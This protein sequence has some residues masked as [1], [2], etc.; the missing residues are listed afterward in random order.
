MYVKQRKANCHLLVTIAQNM[1]VRTLSFYQAVL[2]DISG[3][4]RKC[5]K[6]PFKLRMSPLQCLGR[7]AMSGFARVLASRVLKPLLVVM[8]SYKLYIKYIMEINAEINLRM[9]IIITFLLFSQSSQSTKQR[10]NRPKHL[11]RNSFVCTYCVSFLT[12]SFASQ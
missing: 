7:S 3:S 12:A 9:K 10:R 1:Q 8:V 4:Q 11:K 6:H 2:E 5:P